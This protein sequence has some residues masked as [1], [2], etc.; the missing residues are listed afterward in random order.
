[1]I[2]PFTDETTQIY[3]KLIN[4]LEILAHGLMPPNNPHAVALHSL[5]E[6]VV[7]TRSTREVSSAMVL[8]QKVSI[9][10]C[11]LNILSFQMLSLPSLAKLTNYSNFKLLKCSLKF[12]KL[13][14]FSRH[15]KNLLFLCGCS[16]IVI[17]VFNPSISITSQFSYLVFKLMFNGWI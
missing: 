16:I 15:F 3:D 1:M 2:S 6:A 4:E 12:L 8:L 17:N 5:I 13:L 11:I 10:I 7:L 9:F 14:N